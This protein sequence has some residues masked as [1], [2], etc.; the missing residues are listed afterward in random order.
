MGYVIELIIAAAVFVADLPG[1]ALAVPR[2]PLAALVATAL[3]GLWLCLW[4]TPWR[5][6]GLIGFALGLLLMPLAD[7]RTC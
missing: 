7:R 5:R 1:A 4:R 6:L 3:G 2:P